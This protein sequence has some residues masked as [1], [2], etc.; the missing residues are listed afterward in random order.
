MSC[1]CA[2]DVIAGLVTTTEAGCSERPISVTWSY[3]RDDPYAVRMAFPAAPVVWLLSRDLLVAG[4]EGVD[5][6]G[7]VHLR[8]ISW[9]AGDVTIITIGCGWADQM[10]LSVNTSDLIA[11]LALT[12]DVVPL[13]AES[14]LV[15]S[16][17]RDAVRAWTDGV[18]GA[19]AH[20]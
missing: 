18:D 10:S 15:L 16:E 11:F 1:C 4:V 2:L 17:L 9:P 14:S 5:G 19:G 7:D 13:G 8:T 3:R 20:P 12:D 6:D